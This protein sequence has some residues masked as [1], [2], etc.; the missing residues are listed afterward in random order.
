MSVH[1]KVKLVSGPDN[2]RLFPKAA[3]SGI[4][5]KG[6][7]LTLDSSG[8]VDPRSAANSNATGIETAMLGVGL[9]T[10]ATDAN[11]A[12]N[13]VHVPVSVF[14]PDQVWSIKV[15][16]AQIATDYKIGIA[17]ELGY[18]GTAFDYDIDYPSGGTARTVSGDEFYY[19]TTTEVGAVSVDAVALG[20]VI[21]AHPAKG[22]GRDVSYG[23]RVHVKFTPSACMQI[24]G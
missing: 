2:I 5:T 11:A 15:A 14:S 4:W 7:I 10:E 21:H 22:V 9:T 12:T 13:N 6:D 1:F 24:T 19:L 18:Y 3:D 8:Y 20:A 16:D 23:G 17:Y